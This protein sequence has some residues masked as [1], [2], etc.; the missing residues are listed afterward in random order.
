MSEAQIQKLHNRLGESG[1]GGEVIKFM[2]Y[3]TV[4]AGLS[5]N[6]LLGY[7]RD[8]LG[9]AQWCEAEY[10]LD[11]ISELRA[12]HIYGYARHVAKNLHSK[13]TSIARILAAIK[14]FLRFGMS[15]GL[16]E[17]DLTSLIEGPKPW[18]KLPIVASRDNVLKMLHAPCEEDAFF[19][20]DRALLEVLY[21]TGARASE[22][23]DLRV[24]NV[25][26]KIGYLRCTGK[27]NKERVIPLGQSAIRA[28]EQ[29]LQLER[30]QLA[31]PYSRDYLLLTRTG[32]VLDRTN[33]W[34]IV[35]KYAARVGMPEKVSTH[36]LRHCF[37]THMLSGG[38]DLRSL[39]EMLGHVDISTTQIYTHVDHDRLKSIHKKFHPR[40]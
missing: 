32:K 26:L 31:K 17:D 4:E 25:N 10:G 27:G 12:E 37:A 21:A 8:L 13:E 14:T 30:P 5:Q 38:A 39:Q 15:V 33:I 3:L 11:S 35:K 40:A 28:V 24:K 7:G 1:I 2:H 23:V 20:R 18:H 34:R 9:F 29:Y 36:T 19:L 22:M 16:I 6:T